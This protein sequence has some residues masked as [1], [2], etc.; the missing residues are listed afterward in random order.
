MSG[1]SLIITPGLRYDTWKVYDGESLTASGTTL[2]PADPANYPMPSRSKSKVSPKIGF[3]FKPGGDVNWRLNYG[4]AFNPPG[5]YDLFGTW[6]ASSGSIYRSNSALK[7]ETNTAWDLGFDFIPDNKRFSCRATYFRNTLKNAINNI[8]ISAGP[9][10]IYQKENFGKVV[11]QGLELEAAYQFNNRLRAN[12]NLTNQGSKVKDAPDPTIIGRE[13]SQ[14]PN[15][16]YNIGL[17]YKI[18]LESGNS[19][20]ASLNWNHRDKVHTQEDNSDNHD[21]VYGEYEEYDLLD[22]SIAYKWRKDKEFFINIDNL[23]DEDYYQY[24]LAPGRT[25]TAGM[26]LDF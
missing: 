7:P 9:P 18:P 26:K 22:F 10:A 15:L 24:Y 1:D 6:T 12:F 21:H 4:Q 5:T 11:I 13:Y 17:D 3:L 25:L 16:I 19:I 23:L 2:V 14:N 20:A 8:T